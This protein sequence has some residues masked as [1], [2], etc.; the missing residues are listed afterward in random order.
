MRD[1]QGE[2]GSIEGLEAS[3]LAS[4]IHDELSGKRRNF[5]RVSNQEV[6]VE[7]S[8]Q[9]GAGGKCTRAALQAIVV[10]Q[11]LRLVELAFEGG[12]KIGSIRIREQARGDPSI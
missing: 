12:R 9:N 4:E 5:F 1:R 6:E 11:K 10:Q 7:E 2:L 3:Y 8:K